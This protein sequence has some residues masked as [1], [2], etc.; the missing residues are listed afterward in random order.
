MESAV[1]LCDIFTTSI[2]KNFRLSDDEVA[3][4]NVLFD[5]LKEYSFAERL[6]VDGTV[7]HSA[8]YKRAGKSCSKI[9]QFFSQVT[10][11]EHLFGELSAGICNYRIGSFGSVKAIPYISICYL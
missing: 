3:A 4:I 11:P 2:T 10:E 5:G 7:Y 6:S 1:Q 8:A 9:V